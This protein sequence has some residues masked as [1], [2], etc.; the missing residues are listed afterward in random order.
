MC[1]YVHACVVAQALPQWKALALARH[2]TALTI[3]D[4]TT[5]P[6]VVAAARIKVRRKA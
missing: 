2:P 1:A 4:C 3:A 5:V 6:A